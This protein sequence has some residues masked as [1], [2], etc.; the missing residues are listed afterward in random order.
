[1]TTPRCSTRNPLEVSSEP[2]P[3]RVDAKMPNN[4]SIKKPLHRFKKLVTGIFDFENFVPER[5]LS[6][7]LYFNLGSIWPPDSNV[8]MN[9]LGFVVRACILCVEGRVSVLGVV[10]RV[11]VL[12]VAGA[13]VE[14]DFRHPV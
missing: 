8:I 11:S 6:V 4:F 13:Y 9:V 1:M 3:H 14:V 10:G 5:P 12:G 2:T 7:I